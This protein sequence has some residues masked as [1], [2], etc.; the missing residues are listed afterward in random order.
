[1]FWSTYSGYN[2]MKDSHE[3]SATAIGI[4]YENISPSLFVKHL[5]DESGTKGFHVV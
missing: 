4:D 5:L 2:A 3:V 1:M